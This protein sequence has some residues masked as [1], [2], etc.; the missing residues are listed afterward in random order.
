AFCA[1]LYRY[2]G[3]TDL[4]VGAAIANRTRPEMDPLIGFFVNSLALRADLTGNPPFRELLGRVRAVA[5]GAYEH[6]D[7]PFEKLVAELR[8]ERSLSHA[9]LFQVIFALQNAPMPAL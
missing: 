2:S 9:P 4:V 5:L 7:M 8:P 3:Q 6:Q 1:L